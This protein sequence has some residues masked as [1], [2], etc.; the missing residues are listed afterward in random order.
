MKF[1]L[2][3]WPWQPNLCPADEQ[4][5][6][7][8]M[9]RKHSRHLTGPVFHM[10]TGLHHR[11]GRTCDAISIECFGLTASEDEDFMKP[12]LHG[13]RVILEDIYKLDPEK[14]PE[15]Q[16]MTLFHLGEMEDRFGPIQPEVIDALVR[17]VKVGGLVFF[18]RRS[19]A[20]DRV[21]DQYYKH[22]CGQGIGLLRPVGNFKDLNY[23]DRR[24]E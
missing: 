14:L 13:Y 18:Y 1:D 23:F 7:W 21:S 15:L 12:D 4:F 9:A 11:V 5:I 2:E 20:A 17:R 19:S 3:G 22:A 6:E 24:P 8:L 16:Y 10:G